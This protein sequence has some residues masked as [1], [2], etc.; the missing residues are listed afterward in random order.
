[1]KKTTITM[2]TI[3]ILFFLMSIFCFSCNKDEMNNDKIEIEKKDCTAAFG[4]QGLTLYT[5]N[6][7]TAE[8][9]KKTDHN[10]LI[11]RRQIPDDFLKKMN[12]HEL[13]IQF[14]YMDMAKDVLLFNTNQR[15][16]RSIIDRYNMLQE[17]YKRD[18]TPDY[19]I[20]KLQEV[21]IKEVKNNECHFH[22]LCLRMLSA[23]KEVIGKM[24]KS[25]TLN[26]I[27]TVSQII[28][29]I[30]ELSF[31]DPN[32]QT[33]SSYDFEMIGHGNIM[34]KYEYPPFMEL[35]QSNKK[36]RLYMDGVIPL[37]K[38]LIRLFENCMIK[39]YKQL[40]S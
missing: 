34:I 32:W 16:F 12:T 8:E 15:G 29:E 6:P 23:Q 2:K 28:T 26:Y 38:E 35:M 39:F 30:A 40:N 20:R 10:E 9:W 31:T 1:M 37:D 33:L 17:L 24:N 22:Y 19:F 21:N 11:R 36:V 7:F 18:D 27:N 3:V 14:I 13:F 25:Q 4:T 5:F